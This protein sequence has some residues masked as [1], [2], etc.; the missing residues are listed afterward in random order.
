MMQIWW[1]GGVVDSEEG[2]VTYTA[3]SAMIDMVRRMRKEDGYRLGI[4][5]K[6]RRKMME[7]NLGKKMSPA[8]GA[9]LPS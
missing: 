8:D 5:E 1:G 4:W 9:T 3:W 2:E 7:G 6:K